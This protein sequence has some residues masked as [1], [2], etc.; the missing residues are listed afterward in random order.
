M[1]K[2]YK[3]LTSIAV[4]ALVLTS[5]GGANDSSSNEENAT[6]ISTNKRETPENKS[7]AEFDY[8]SAEDAVNAY[9]EMMDEYEALLESGNQAAA[10]NYLK[11]I[12]KLE[13]YVNSSFSDQTEL[14]QNMTDM[15]KGIMELQSEYLDNVMDMYDDVLDQMGDMPGASEAKEALKDAQ[16]EIDDAMKDAQKQMD[17]A[18]KGYGGGF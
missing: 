5:C 4:S 2:M 14:L 16:K 13:K 15:S 7:G 11:D 6:S 18:M 17:D 8:T 12:E 1:K 3:F 9:S 10:E